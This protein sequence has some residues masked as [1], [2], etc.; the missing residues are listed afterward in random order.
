M[1]VVDLHLDPRLPRRR[2]RGLFVG[3]GRS[4]S[5]R[6]RRLQR[7]APPARPWQIA[8]VRILGLDVGSRRI[9]VAVTDELG[10]AAHA[11]TTLERRGTRKDVA[12][13]VALA[14]RYAAE[15]LVVGLPVEPDGSEGHRAARVR[16]L[17]DA[18]RE[19]GL[20]VDECDEQFSTVEAEETLL[21]ADLSRRK[22]KRVIDRA[23]AAVILTRWLAEHAGEASR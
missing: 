6:G 13:I 19:A 4:V 23:A 7:I 8:T 18:L 20:A 3:H 10:V 11:V 22:R 12:Q 15:R 5:A 17:V 16:V 9:G 1:L 21:E 2:G 14:E